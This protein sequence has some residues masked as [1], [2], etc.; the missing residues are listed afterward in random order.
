MSWPRVDS[1]FNDK[2]QLRRYSFIAY[3]SLNHHGR[4]LG[5]NGLL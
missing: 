1:F 3:D 2:E 4:G 5:R